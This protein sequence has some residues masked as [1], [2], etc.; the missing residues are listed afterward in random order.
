H[1]PGLLHRNR[2]LAAKP[3]LAAGR[4]LC[5][6]QHRADRRYRDWNGACAD[7]GARHQLRP[8]HALLANGADGLGVATEL[9]YSQQERHGRT[10]LANPEAALLPGAGRSV[11]G[12]RPPQPMG[13]RSVLAHAAFHRLLQL[14]RHERL[15]DEVVSTAAN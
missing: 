8:D 15:G 11:S 6:S 2:P 4:W 13:V 10:D 14:L 5:R 3:R 12:W 7:T 9:C 1:Q